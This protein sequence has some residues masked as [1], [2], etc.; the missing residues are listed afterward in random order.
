MAGSVM[1]QGQ[2]Q[3]QQGQGQGQGQG[4]G[5]RRGGGQGF[6]PAAQM[7]N[8]LDYIQQSLGATDQEWTVLKPVRS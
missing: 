8:T 3:Q 2:G 7:A 4:G 5:G 1:A 6:D